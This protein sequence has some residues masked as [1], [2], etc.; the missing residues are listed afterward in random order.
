MDVLIT[1][2]A[3]Q[4]ISAYVSNHK[5]DRDE[6]ADLRS[7]VTRAL[8]GEKPEAEVTKIEPAVPIK[9]SVFPSYIVCLEDGKKLKIL[10]RHLM[11][12][13]GMTPEQYRTRWGLPAHYPMV[14]PDYT[15]KRSDMAKEFGLGIRSREAE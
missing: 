1:E 2:L 10:R 8:S 12:A 9:K 3:G 5:I 6:L 7:E 14:A 4:I 11:A 13:Y 15:A